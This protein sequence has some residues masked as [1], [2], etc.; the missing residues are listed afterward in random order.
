MLGHELKSERI[1]QTLL[2]FGPEGS[3]KFLT[4]LE[5]VRVLNCRGEEMVGGT[6][7][8]TCRCPSCKS[9]Q[10]LVSRDLLVIAKPNF[11]NTFELWKRHGVGR[12]SL[13]FFVRDL[14]R[15]L[16][17]IADE[18]RLSRE[19][20]SLQ[21][22]VHERERILARSGEVIETALAISSS[23]EGSVI[24]ID[25]IREAQRFL[26]LRSGEGRYRAVILDGAER[27]NIEASNCF[28]KISEDTPPHAIIILITANRE[29]IK[30]TIQSRC[31]AYR[32]KP[33]DEELMGE[34]VRIRFGGHGE[35]QNPQENAVAR[36]FERLVHGENDVLTLTETAQE[37][38][39][40]GHATMFFEHLAHRLG[41]RIP[42]VAG[43]SMDEVQA[44]ENLLKKI[45]FMHS[46]IVQFH[47]NV[48]TALT[49]MLLNDVSTIVRYAS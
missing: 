40:R 30:E 39:E 42:H 26:S 7:P 35:V 1:P 6:S 17:S 38:A 20:E 9:I 15:I 25:R 18:A 29:G 10:N 4:A 27:M 24:G 21:D 11:K 32:F 13:P 3:G 14:K 31:R 36:Y 19:F 16:V 2:F 23:L 47:G 28:L 46:S 34:I 5:L 33:L 37:I 48:L 8:D 45:D 12:E 43:Q 22:M 49:D 44:I 41:K